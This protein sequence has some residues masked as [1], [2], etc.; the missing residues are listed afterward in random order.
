[1]GFQGMLKK[2]RQAHVEKELHLG[3]K[4]ISAE[5][6]HTIK[7]LDLPCH[8]PQ[9][10]PSRTDCPAGSILP[11]NRTA[12]QIVA[13]KS[14][15]SNPN[16][17]RSQ[18]SLELSMWSP[19]F[20]AEWTLCAGIRN[21]APLCPLEEENAGRCCCWNNVIGH[22]KNREKE[23]CWDWRRGGVGPRTGHKS[24][25]FRECHQVLGIEE[26]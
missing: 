11:S 16:S 15:L 14:P 8:T 25:R 10:C 5:I 23:V 12:R 3:P 26:V 6:S 21:R 9:R 13:P 22:M 4:I 20:L 1:M 19:S 7:F 18:T 24:E 2:G 17:P